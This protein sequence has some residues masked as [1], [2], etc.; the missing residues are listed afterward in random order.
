MYLT[1]TSLD[2]VAFVGSLL[3]CGVVVN[4][5]IVIV[6]HV[7]QLRQEGM[8]RREAIVQAGINRFRPV[9]MTAFTTIVGFG[10]LLVNSIPNIRGMGLM[11]VVGIAITFVVSITLLPSN[12]QLQ[13]THHRTQ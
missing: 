11:A 12:L 13:A 8:K 4:N 7:N 6:D 1:G 3:M 10:S 2:T 9:M 5:G